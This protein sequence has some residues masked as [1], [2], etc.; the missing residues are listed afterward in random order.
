[1]SINIKV[2]KVTFSRPSLGQQHVEYVL[3]TEQQANDYAIGSIGIA[4]GLGASAIYD[5]KPV[6]FNDPCVVELSQLVDTNILKII[7]N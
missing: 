3:G 2:Y 5:V 1:M 4:S 6:H 7:C